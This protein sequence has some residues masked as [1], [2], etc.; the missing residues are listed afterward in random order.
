MVRWPAAAEAAIRM[1]KVEWLAENEGQ[2]VVESQRNSGPWL[3][4]KL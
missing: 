2:K 3:L 1:A 4:E